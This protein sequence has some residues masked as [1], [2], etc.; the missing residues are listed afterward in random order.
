MSRLIVHEGRWAPVSAGEYDRRTGTVSVNLTVVDEVTARFGHDAAAVI[1][2]IVAHERVHVLSTP[3]AVPH[4]EEL[5]A[6]AAATD[7]AGGDVVAHIDQVLAEA[8][9]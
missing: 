9:T 2:A 5:R 4:E 6:R 7:A 8:W 1:A 3:Q